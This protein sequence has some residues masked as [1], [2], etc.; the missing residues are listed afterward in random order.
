MPLLRNKSNTENGEAIKMAHRRFKRRDVGSEA[1]CR[2]IQVNCRRARADKWD[3]SIF[4]SPAL[5]AY[6]LRLP[7]RGQSS[8]VPSVLGIIKPSTH[9]TT[10][11][12]IFTASLY[13]HLL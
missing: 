10:I 8:V 11:S 9:E 2:H 5:P 3:G 4:G 1:T 6:A 13:S 7:A 12:A